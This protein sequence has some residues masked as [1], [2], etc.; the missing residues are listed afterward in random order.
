MGVDVTNI[1][2]LKKSL[3][4]GGDSVELSSPS[5][6]V[7]GVGEKDAA[8]Y[9]DYTALGFV[10]EVTVQSRKE[11]QQIG[12]IGSKGKKLLTQKGKTVMRISRLVTHQGNL[13]NQF[14]DTYGGTQSGFDLGINHDNDFD[15]E[16]KMMLGFLDSDRDNFD[17]TVI[18]SGGKI[19]GYNMQGRQGSKG[20]ADSISIMYATESH[21]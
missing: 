7:L 6:I 20:I 11:G 3:V 5:S 17:E 21:L 4:N 16:F 18:M 19:V 1:N 14:I 9:A 2:N 8:E 15:K 10:Q 13:L 12:E